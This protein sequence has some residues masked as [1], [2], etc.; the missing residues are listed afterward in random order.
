MFRFSF[1]TIKP[2][3]TYGCVIIALALM[4]VLA[5]IFYAQPWAFE[6][7]AIEHG[8]YG[9]LWSAHFVHLNTMHLVLNLCAWVL[10]ALLFEREFTPLGLI[11]AVALMPWLIGLAI[12]L[13]QPSVERYV[14]F[15]GVLHGIFALGVG[16][17][18]ANT[19]EKKLAC[20]LLIGLIAKL[21]YE[22][23]AQHSV[24]TEQMIG[25]R[26]L[27][28]AHFYGACAGLFLTSIYLGSD[29]WLATKLVRK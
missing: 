10:I 8:H 11:I 17:L 21:S 4:L 23:F 16:Q 14:G 15:S 2:I 1:M 18:L 24:L 25:G 6:R 20:L 9:L 5:Q 22:H 28:A 7:M 26:V 13:Y 12:W 29:R 27:V 3:S 19:Q